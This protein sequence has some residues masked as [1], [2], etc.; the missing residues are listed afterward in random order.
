MTD[1]EIKAYKAR[2]RRE[3]DPT[4]HRQHVKAW[5]IRNREKWLAL[6]RAYYQRRKARIAAGLNLIDKSS[7]A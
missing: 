4:K 7:N 6:K 2:L 3:A 5:K 1:K